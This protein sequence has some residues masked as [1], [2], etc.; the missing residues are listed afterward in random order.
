MSHP[1]LV[2]L[3]IFV[4][5]PLLELYVLIEV[6]GEIG[7]GRCDGDV[8]QRTLPVPGDAKTRCQLG[9]VVAAIDLAPDAMDWRSLAGVSKQD[10]VS[11]RG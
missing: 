5:A 1:L 2:F 10:R 9:T 4:G 3:T 8:A 7:R 6:G 11:A